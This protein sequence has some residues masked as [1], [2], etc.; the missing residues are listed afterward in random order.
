MS[1]LPVLGLMNQKIGLRRKITDDTTFYHEQHTFSRME[2]FPA[3]VEIKQSVSFGQNG[4]QIPTY[5]TIYTIA[6]INKDDEIIL[7]NGTVRT[8]L[9]VEWAVDGNGAFSHSVVSV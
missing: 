6:Q 8:A 5:A 1:S 7:P 2:T 3:R 4:T 9:S